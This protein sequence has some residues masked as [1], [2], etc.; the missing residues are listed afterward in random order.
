M[1]RKID[2][3]TI[4]VGPGT[5][6]APGPGNYALSGSGMSGSPPSIGEPG[7]LDADGLPAALFSLPS[8][9]V[10]ML[11]AALQ[12]HLNDPVNAHS[13]VAVTS[14]PTPPL[15]AETVAG[16][17]AELTGAVSPPP[18]MIG[19]VFNYAPLSGVP[20]WGVLKL[21]EAPFTPTHI[22][23]EVAAGTF[24]PDYWM[25]PTP[26][27]DWEFAEDGKDPATDVLWNNITG[28]DWGLVAGEARAAGYTND[29]LDI[30]RTRTVRADADDYSVR[31]GVSGMVF[32]ADRGVLALIHWPTGGN[33]D[34][35]LGQTLLDRCWAALLL[36][37]GVDTPC[38]ASVQNVQPGDGEAGGIFHL[39]TDA[40]G[41]YDP[42]AYPGRASGQYDLHELHTGLS[43]VDGLALPSPWNT[44]QVRQASSIHPGAGQVR[45]GT[46]PDAGV[47]PTTYGIPILGAQVGAYNPAPA[48]DGT[49]GVRVLGHTAFPTDEAGDRYNFFRYRLPYLKDYTEATGLKYTP[50]APNR[51]FAIGEAA[52]YLKLV[53]P[54]ST[55]RDDLDY[56]TNAEGGESL[57]QAGNYPDFGEDHWTWQVARFRQVFWTE[58]EVGDALGTLWLVHFKRE[59]DF[60]AFVRDGVMPWDGTDGY[61]IYGMTPVDTDINDP[62][63]IVNESSTKKPASF[64]F[65]SQAYHT[66]RREIFVADTETTPTVDTATW[67]Y[68]LVN[69]TP[70]MWVSGVAYFTPLHAATNLPGFRISALTGSISDFCEAGFRVDDKPLTGTD[71]ALISSRNPV[72]ASIAGFSYEG[73]D[74]LALENWSSASGLTFTSATGLTD[75]RGARK[76][77]IE[78]PLSKLGSNGGGAYSDTNGPVSGDTLDFAITGGNYIALAG[79][80]TTPAFLHEVYPVLHLKPLDESAI[81]ESAAGAGTIMAHASAKTVLFHSTGFHLAGGVTPTG[82]F[83]NYTTGSDYAYSSLLVSQKDSQ[84]WFLDE[85]YR[86]HFVTGDQ[87]GDHIVGPGM[88]GWEDGAIAVPVRAGANNG[89]TYDAYSWMKQQLHLDPLP[90]GALQVRGLWQRSPYREA[91]LTAP[92]PSAGLLA[93]PAVDYTNAVWRPNASEMSSLPGTPTQPNYSAASGDRSYVRA[94]DANFCR[95]VTPLRQDGQPYVFFRIDGLDLED[96]AYLVPGP[97]NLTL[98]GISI[99][100]KIPGLTTWMDLGRLD[101]DGPSKQHMTQDGAGC[102]VNGPYTYTYVDAQ[103]GLVY[104]QVQAHVGPAASLIQGLAVGDEFECPVL[105]KVVI[106]KSG[107]AAVYYDL[108]YQKTGPGTFDTGDGQ[109][110]GWES[111][112]VRGLHGLRVL[113]PTEAIPLTEEMQEVKED[114]GITV[115]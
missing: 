75:S 84:E 90:S 15:F 65:G 105:V 6:N 69:G 21:S 13:S 55:D 82:R 66:L 102:R 81:A 99:L 76:Q 92:F 46:D 103:T 5:A 112:V 29:D 38:I 10:A 37:Q 74:V 33:I 49:L 9:R 35:Y 71:P 19:Q 3:V 24:Y 83:G 59:R 68:T 25:A 87:P 17:V 106:R 95:S 7:H 61:S 77:R 40:D 57:K 27:Q 36:G 107:T 72:M 44:A 52:R 109:G 88:G 70:V 20:D 50:R 101:G 41:N 89:S 14:E 8:D 39:G 110:R 86:W 30:V 48:M 96:F 114:L 108:G 54:Y 31:V 85:T 1:P 32:P 53:E 94:F 18:P 62:A 2:P 58:A 34:D 43:D 64:G 93:Y 51:P 47:T 12:Q 100:V 73:T 97:G 42:F 91:G 115:L 16:Q 113:R 80:Q 56:Y 4:A 45:L 78:F 23:P 26:S 28:N 79:D 104:S 98:S 60:E 67:D 22:N 111:T 11:A 63:N